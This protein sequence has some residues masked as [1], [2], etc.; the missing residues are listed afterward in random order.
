MQHRPS[1]VIYGMVQQ[2]SARHSKSIQSLGSGSGSCQ[3]KRNGKRHWCFSENEVRTLL[4][5]DKVVGQIWDPHAQEN[6]LPVPCFSSF[7]DLYLGYAFESYFY[8]CCS[9]QL[10]LLLL[11][12]SYSF[13]LSFIHSLLKCLLST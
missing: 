13:N 2:L 1:F 10:F 5:Y 8:P 11:E 3:V 4:Y 9:F 6:S 12:S 7:H